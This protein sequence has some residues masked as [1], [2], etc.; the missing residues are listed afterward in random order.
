MGRMMKN[1]MKEYGVSSSSAPDTE[2]A[3][4]VATPLVRRASAF[5]RGKTVMITGASSGIGHAMALQLAAAGARVGLL[6]RRQ[7]QL[8]ALTAACQT[9]DGSG[10]GRTAYRVLDVTN[11]EATLIAIGELEGE[12]GPTD[13][14]IANAGVSTLVR[15][16][17][18]NAERAAS[19]YAVNVFGALNA[20]EA[21]LG[22]MLQRRRGQIVG[23]SSL[24]AFR[25]LPESHAYCA[26][27]SALSAH[28][29]GLR[30]ELLPRGVVVTTIC[31]GFIKSEI[32]SK[33]RFKMPFLME[34]NVGAARI[35]NAVAAEKA[36]YAFPRRLYWLIR[37]SRFIPSALVARLAAPP[38]NGFKAE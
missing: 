6:A 18:F 2:S 25:S 22:G 9:L 28:L 10:T 27:K 20:I 24:A 16:A 26:T 7:P 31:P 17:R 35:L 3:E 36:V 13:I 33:N 29:E 32:T 12:L 5:F 11:R 1:F 37:A 14:L 34:T 8:E 15:A 38:P 4:S 19:L 30:L 21:V 23:I